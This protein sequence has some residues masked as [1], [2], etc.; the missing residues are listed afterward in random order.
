MFERALVSVSDKTNLDLLAAHLK[1]QDPPPQVLSTG[2]TAKA[3]RELG[4]KVTDIEEYTGF[5]ESFGGRIKTLHPRVHGGILYRRGIDE[6]DAARLEIAP[7]DLV[8]VNL[9][10]F[11]QTYQASDDQADWVE[12]IDIGGPTL[13]RAAA[14]NCENVVVLCRP[15]D[16]APVLAEQPLSMATRKRLRNLAFAHTASYDAQIAAALEPEPFPAQLTIPLE[17]EQ[18]LRYGENPHQGAASYRLAGQPPAFTQLQGKELSYNNLLDLEAALMP[19]DP[20][21]IR[22]CVVKHA[23]P[24]GLAQAA[25]TA[26]SFELAWEADSKS[27]FGSVVAFSSE[28]DEATAAAFEGR[29]VEVIAAP[30]FSAEALE[31]LSAKSNLRL[32]ELT[33]NQNK[34]PPAFTHQWVGRQGRVLLQQPDRP[35][36][37]KLETVTRK[38]FPSSLAPLAEFAMTAAGCLKSNAIALAATAPGG[39]VTL[40]LGGGQPNRVDAVEIALG[41]ANGHS[42]EGAVLASDAFFPFADNI[43]AAAAAGVSYIVQ[44]GGSMRDA[45]VIEACDRLGV[46]MAFTGQRR[47]RH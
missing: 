47:F 34:V 25:T 30:A 20:D 9:Y 41:R 23:A 36:A 14:K 11:A 2:G 3:L 5:P 12:Q 42:L 10:P 35:Q 16:Y 21:S 39:L 6:Q 46:A 22:C 40:G 19:L 44:P 24:C 15:E 17:R 1:A 7:I 27:A 32:L 13:L 31:I 37:F 38:P 18:S 26:Q 4:V 29:F 33:R 45:E 43:E 28:L 8:V